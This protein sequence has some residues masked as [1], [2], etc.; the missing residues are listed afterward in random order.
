MKITPAHDF[1]DYAVWQ[2]HRDELAVSEQMHGGLINIFTIDAAIRDN[3]E[4][5]GDL[6]PAKYIGMDRY[7]ARKQI[8]ADL[9]AAGLLEK[10]DDHKLM[11]PR[12]DRSGTVSPPP[13]ACLTI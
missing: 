1:N 10:V 5:E 3:D 7:F 12:G 8:V 13:T 6:I 4:H 9:D 11:V 2:R